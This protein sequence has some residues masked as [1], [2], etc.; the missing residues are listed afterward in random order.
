MNRPIE[1]ANVILKNKAT[2]RE[3]AKIMGISKS[4]VHKDLTERLPKL[5]LSLYEKVRL[6]LNYNNE[7]KHIRGGISTKMKYIKEIYHKER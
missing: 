2:I 7:I 1:I 4:T 3:V 5:D 6:L